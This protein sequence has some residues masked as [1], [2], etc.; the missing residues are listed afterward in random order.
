[1]KIVIA[2]PLRAAGIDILKAQPDWEIVTSSPAEYTKHLSDAEVLIASR[3]ARVS[4]SQIASAK[5]LRVIAFAGVGTDFVD[6]E[7]ATAAGV[8]VMNMP[9]ESAVAVAE[10]TLGL[11]LAMARQ[12]PQAIISTRGGKWDGKRFLGTEL[13]RKTLGVMGLGSIGREVVRRAR[14]FE[15]KIV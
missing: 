8:L 2:E 5:K 15:M 11:M 12:I 7:A 14:G 4:A 6:L 13:R 1:M 9:G 10:H 3:L